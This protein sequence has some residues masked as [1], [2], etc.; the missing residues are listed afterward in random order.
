MNYTI[1]SHTSAVFALSSMLIYCCY[2]LRPIYD[3]MNYYEQEGRNVTNSSD[4]QHSSHVYT[5]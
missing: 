4:Q 2:D 3:I 5:M 1:L